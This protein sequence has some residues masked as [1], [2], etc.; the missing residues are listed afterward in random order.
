MCQQARIRLFKIASS[1][2]KRVCHEEFKIAS[3]DEKRRVEVKGT[4]AESRERALREARSSHQKQVHGNQNPINVAQGKN[5]VSFSSERR[6]EV[7]SRGENTATAS[8][9]SF[10]R[11]PWLCH[12]SICQT[13]VVFV[14]VISVTS[15]SWVGN[16]Q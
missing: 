1:D 7:T 14:F 13:E 3:G 16:H 9:L 10:E 6:P 12:L 11:N 4:P 15:F 2:K 8:F 5:C